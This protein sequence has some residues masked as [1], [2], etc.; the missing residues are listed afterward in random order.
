MHLRELVRASIPASPRR[1][2][3]Q[4]LSRSFLF[5]WAVAP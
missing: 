4:M 3:I 1:N 2:M 5:V